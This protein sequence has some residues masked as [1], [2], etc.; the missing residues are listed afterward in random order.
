MA[1]QRNIATRVRIVLATLLLVMVASSLCLAMTATIAAAAEHPGSCGSP[2]PV[3]K[4][5]CCGFAT[6]P[7]QQA[8][9]DVFFA[10]RPAHVSSPVVQESGVVLDTAGLPESTAPPSTPLRL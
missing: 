7:A 5:S 8:R 2:T 1:L 9:V 6:Q 3:P 4:A 10:V